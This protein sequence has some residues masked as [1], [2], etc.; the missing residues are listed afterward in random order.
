MSVALVL[1]FEVIFVELA[2]GVAECEKV[3]EVEP[4]HVVLQE[5]VEDNN[6]EREPFLEIDSVHTKD[7]VALPVVE[8]DS[9][10]EWE[11]VFVC[12]TSPLRVQRVIVVV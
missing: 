11:D 4:K 3:L 9:V 10:G 12:V 5:S 7:R 8:L 1:L 6:E 2:L